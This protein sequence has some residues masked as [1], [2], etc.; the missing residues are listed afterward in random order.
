MNRLLKTAAPLAALVL[1]SAAPLRAS[2]AKEVR[3]A[4]K[5]L[6]SQ[7]LKKLPASK[8]SVAVMPLENVE[9]Q[10]TVL[11]QMIAQELSREVVASGK[12]TVV[13]R[14]DLD[15]IFKEWKLSTTGAISA[16][17]TQKIG[18]LSGAD[19]LLIG[20]V[21]KLG[22]DE[23]LAEAKLVRTQTGEILQMGSVT[24][25]AGAEL[26]K[27]NRPV[28][29]GKESN[30]DVV[31][32]S[33]KGSGGC[34]WFEAPA[35]VRFPP[36]E[37]RN[38]ARA[39]AIG[40]A[41][42]KALMAASGNEVSETYTN[43]GDPTFEEADG[44]IDSVLL[45]TRYGRIAEEKIVSEDILDGQDCKGCLYR[46]VL[47][48]CV[49]PPR[50]SADPGFRADL[51]LNQAHFKEGDE[52][53]VIIS[54]SR[55]AY[56]YLF[57]VDKDWNAVLAFPNASA[58][59]NLVRSGETFVYPGPVHK[60]LGVHLVAELP[61]GA[62]FSAESL[63]LIATKKPLEGLSDGASIDYRKLIQDLDA[64]GQDWTECANAFTIRKQ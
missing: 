1:L 15:Q 5:S 22:K 25:S 7:I 32:L 27:L 34:F 10:A 6:A 3:S 11:G 52:A 54:V 20:S 37:T 41:R 17:T 51:T 14:K 26:L 55:D 60:Q 31:A 42:Q 21:Q 59:D 2:A 49:H 50:P 23:I 29:A 8:L 28:E 43:F 24:K 57:S 33:R 56:V 39:R 13:E 36:N 45:L 30:E 63:R 46:V 40:R 12:F 61:A 44:L 35:T 9:G 38:Q 47:Q 16:Q 48:A 58:R 19:Y 4:A 53:Q 64:S 62:D 18:E